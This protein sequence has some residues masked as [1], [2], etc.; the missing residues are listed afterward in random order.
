[1]KICM[2]IDF[3]LITFINLRYQYESEE[4]SL[5][6]NFHAVD[7]SGFTT[8]MIKLLR[9]SS[10]Q[11]LS[12]IRNVLYARNISNMTGLMI[13]MSKPFTVGEEI[14]PSGLHALSRN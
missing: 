9:K 11:I 4:K 3:K 1:M 6:V 13:C 14:G 12:L 2:I 5:L 8:V 7:M 10:Q